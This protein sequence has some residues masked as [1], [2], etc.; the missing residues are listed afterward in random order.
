MIRRPPRSTLFPYTTLFRSRVAPITAV[1]RHAFVAER[2]VVLHGILRIDGRERERDVLRHAPVPRFPARE[3]DGPAHVLHVRVHR[4]QQP[5][6]RH[7][8]PEPE[9]WRLAPDPPAA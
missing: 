9:I 2:E 7:R 4:H 3:A 5:R 6:R 8:G 1:A